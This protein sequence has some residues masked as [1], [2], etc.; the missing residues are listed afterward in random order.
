MLRLPLLH[1]N[2][3]GI[4]KAPPEPAEVLV[5]WQ[6]PLDADEEPRSA[7]RFALLKD[8]LLVVAQLPLKYIRPRGYF[9]SSIF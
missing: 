3:Y 1:R 7:H 9:G 5:D 4:R 2:S 8:S 6:L